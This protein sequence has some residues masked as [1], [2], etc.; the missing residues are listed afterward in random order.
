MKNEIEDTLDFAEYVTNHFEANHKPWVYTRDLGDLEHLRFTDDY[1][2]YNHWT[3]RSLRFLRQ[4]TVGY[5]KKSF[6]WEHSIQS[7]RINWFRW[8]QIHWKVQVRKESNKPD[9]QIKYSAI[10]TM[11]EEDG[12]YL[13]MFA[14]YVGR[15]VLKFL[16]AE[17]DN[18]YAKAIIEKMVEARKIG[19][20]LEE[21]NEDGD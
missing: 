8:V 21:D 10:Y 14:P 15:E 13:V 3:K 18:P 4:I 2:D 16:R 12:E 19:F 5:F 7:K 9:G 20:G 6:I 1:T 17:P 11:W